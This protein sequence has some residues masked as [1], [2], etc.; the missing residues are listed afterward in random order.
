LI[1]QDLERAGRELRDARLQAGLTLKTLALALGVSHPTVL[2]TERGS[3]GGNPV[4][5]AR[6]ASLVGLRARLQVYPDGDALRD[7][8]Q[9]KLMRRFRVQIGEVGTWTFEVPIPDSRDRRALD[10]V[11]TVGDGRIGFEFY[12]RLADAQA[13]LRSA[14]LKKRDAGLDRM[15]VVVQSTRLNRRA[16]A[17]AASTMTE[18]FPQS[19]RV[20]MTELGAGRLPA[21]DGVIVF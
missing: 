9:V 13:Q 7:I 8:G 10:A 17:L 15:M 16:L 3:A 19:S 11:L 1:R 6:H 18:L 5:L 21:T 2:R 4:L 14:N 12:T 20:L